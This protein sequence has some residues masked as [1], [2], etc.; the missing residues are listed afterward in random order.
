MTYN[1]NGRVALVTGGGSGLGRAIS[2]AYARCGA[3][4][5]LSDINEVGAQ[6]T[7]DAIHE[8][9]GSASVTQLDVTDRDAVAKWVNEI[10]KT[11][12]Q[13][14]FAVNNA[15]IDGDL[16]QYRLA[17]A[18]YDD[19]RRVMDV[20]VNGV[21]H[22][23]M[24][25]LP[26]MAAQKHGVIINMASIAGLDGVA[27]GAAYAASKHAVVGITKSVALEYV[28]KG[29]RVN[30]ICPGIIDTPMSGRG[31]E[32]LPHFNELVAR[33]IPARRIGTPEEIASAAMFLSSDG[34]SFMVG[35][36]MVVDGGSHAG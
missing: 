22:C 1:F 21:W 30:A 26:L 8:N 29:I 12:G 25:Q 5:A 10:H 16:G 23:L 11:H 27:R 18:P 17:D 4:V 13:I 33:S 28:R 35:E 24:A 36:C 3:F 20:N 15:G 32:N 7:A 31:K 2:Y 34:A 14:D 6:E 19:F 9:G